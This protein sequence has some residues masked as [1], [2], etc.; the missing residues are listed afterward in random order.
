MSMNAPLMTR[1]Q[2]AVHFSPKTT[3]KSKI[4]LFNLISI[5]LAFHTNEVVSLKKILGSKFKKVPEVGI[6]KKKSKFS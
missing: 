5:R 2:K 4:L 3:L 6:M 1:N